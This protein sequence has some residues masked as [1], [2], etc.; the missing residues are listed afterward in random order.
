MIWER[1][2]D[3][4]GKT[5]RVTISDE[6]E[7]LCSAVAEGR[8]VIGLWDRNQK[9]QCLS[10][11][12]YLVESMEDVNDC[13]LDQAVRR[14]MGIPFEIAL[15]RRLVI[16]E[17]EQKDRL[18]LPAELQMTEAGSIVCGEDTLRDYIKY[19]Y[20]FYEYGLWAIWDKDR[21]TILGVGGIF[22]MESDNEAVWQN[23][24]NKNDTPL[25]LGYHIF[26]PYRNRG[27]GTEACRSMLSYASRF[28]DQ[29]YARV[30]DENYFSV[31]L[32]E[33]LGFHLIARTHNELAGAQ[34]LY[35]W[36]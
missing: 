16:R 36:S 19:Q 6:Y 23:H 5:Y 27:Y 32:L 7:A 17:F 4:E 8:A 28:T 34:C 26:S 33:K 24:L 21:K 22:P 25:E 9:N 18:L 13:I 31:R 10:M 12:L 30:S 20:G 15:T 1:E 3:V 35:G 11:A 14:A 29:V 2:I